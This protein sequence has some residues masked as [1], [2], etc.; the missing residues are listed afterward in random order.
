MSAQEKLDVGSMRRGELAELMRSMG[1]PP[2]RAGQLFSWLHQK[3]AAD[4]SQMTNLPA[5]LRG[6]L[7]R[8]CFIAP[9][10]ELRRQTASDG[11]VK[12]LFALFDGNAVESVLMRHDY[13]NSL[14]ISTQVGCRMGCRFCAST[15]GGKVRDLTASE[16]LGQIYA[17]GRLTGQKVDSVVLMGIGEPLDNM[18]NLLR[19]LDLVRDPD[20]LGLSHRHLSLSTCGLVEQI[21]ALAAHQYQL[22]LSVSLHACDNETRDKIMPVNRRY[23]MEQLLAACRRYFDQTGRRVSFEYSLIA[24]VN[25]SPAQAGRLASLLAGMNCHVNLIR[26]NPVPEAGFCSAGRREAEQFRDILAQNGIAATI[27]R[28]LGREIDAA[29]GQLRRRALKGEHN[30]VDD[31]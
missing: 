25:D 15:I 12:F 10:G 28:E 20:G 22:T 8:Q 27:R 9:V 17:A 2:F 21:D 14:C 29:C 31:G 18:E 24:G 13:G 16:M 6:A 4:F 11:T 26:V 3:Q 1:Q 5:A 23:P 30:D 19:F 7:E